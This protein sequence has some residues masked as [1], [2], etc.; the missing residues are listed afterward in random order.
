MIDVYHQQTTGWFAFTGLPK[1]GMNGFIKVMPVQGTGQWIQLH[2]PT[3]FFV[4]ALQLHR[5]LVNFLF[6]SN[7]G[8]LS[9]LQGFLFGFAGGLLADQYFLL[10]LPRKYALPFSTVDLSI[11]KDNQVIVFNESK[12]SLYC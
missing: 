7:I 4:G 10:F 3:Q 9:Y 6:Q 11:C 8:I 2:H 5:A 1:Q 12:K